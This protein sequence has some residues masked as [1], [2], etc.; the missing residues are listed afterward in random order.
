MIVRIKC[1]H[2]GAEF[3]AEA[4]E[5]AVLCQECGKENWISKTRVVMPP[6]KPA[7]EPKLTPCLDCE[8]P[9]SRTAV[10]CPNCGRFINVRFRLVWQ[11][12]CFVIVASAIWGLWDALWRWLAE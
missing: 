11:V 1:S 10:F 2:C 5:H 12:F 7:E 6:A 3:D 8:K 4:E 9:I